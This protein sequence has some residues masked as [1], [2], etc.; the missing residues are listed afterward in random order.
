MACGAYYFFTPGTLNIG[1]E[2][3]SAPALF[4]TSLAA[5]ITATADSFTLTSNTVRGGGSLSGYNCF[6]IDEGS[7]Q[8]EFVCGTA[9]GTAVTNVTR[10]ISPSDGVSEVESLKFAHRRGASVKI[11]DF[12]II[13]LLR[14]QNNGEATFENVLRYAGDVVPSGASDLADVGYVLSVVNG[15]AVDFDALTVAGRA[16]ETVATGTLVYFARADQ[17]WYKVD[18]NSTSTWQGR[19][20]GITQG[21]GTNGTAIGG[22]G[23]LLK[24]RSTVNTGLVAGALYYATTSG[25]ISNTSS[26]FP[27][28]E[29]DSTTVLNFD[30]ATYNSPGL[31]WNNTFTG[32]NTFTGMTIGFGTASTT[33]YA[34]VGTSTY[35]KSTN[36]KMVLVELQGPGGNGAV[37]Q[38]SDRKAGGGGAGGYCRRL[39]AAASLSAT[40]SITI[41]NTGTSS[42]FGSFCTANSGTSATA[43][44]SSGAAGGTATGGDITLTG[45]AG[46]AGAGTTASGISLSGFGGNSI[47]G[48]GGLGVLAGSDGS[49]GVGYGGGGAGGNANGATDQNG[50][51]GAQ[52]VV[53][54][55]E[56]F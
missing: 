3:P 51:A 12:P 43:D 35:T 47:L 36:V 42:S 22:G 21:E 15:G 10:G 29:T 5:P 38:S 31:G 13:Q 44:S 37:A 11:T 39:I 18:I 48:S 19:A 46:S 20:V 45:Q 30:P 52:G 24:G 1:A 54:V 14:N 6:T 33:V 25:G 4:E 53:I 41:G 50:G 8:A 28:G 32:T 26:V 2:L 16:G 40:T 7:A 27:I 56:Y 34:T 23:V 9:S 55:T 49:A 17:K